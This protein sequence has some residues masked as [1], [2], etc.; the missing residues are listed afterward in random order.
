[1]RRFLLLAALLLVPA[2]ARAQQTTV[3]ATVTDP[4]GTAYNFSTGYAALVCPGNQQPTFNGFTVPR[5]FTITGFD[6]NGTFT[7]VVYDVNSILPAGCSYQWHITWQDGITSFITGTITSVTG[8][9]VNESTEISSYSVLLPGSHAGSVISCTTAGGVAYQNGT[10]NILTCDSNNVWSS[11]NSLLTL[12]NAAAGNVFNLVNPTAATNILNQHSPIAL[13][14]G[15]YWNGA[16]SAN[17][18][19][20]FQNLVQAGTNPA[21]T[22]T[23]TH[24]GSGAGSFTFAGM[25]NLGEVASASDIT[26]STDVLAMQTSAAT[27]IA[28]FNS[29]NFKLIGNYWN[30]AASAADTWLLQNVLGTGTNPTTT[31]TVTHTGSSGAV[32]VSIPTVGVTEYCGATSGATQ[33]CTKTVQTTPIVVFGD[34]TLNTATTQSITTLPF[35]DALYSCTGSDLTTAAGV[36]SFTSYLAASVTISETGGA[37]TDHL[38]YICVGR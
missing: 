17:D 27:N 32:A 8:A 37:N 35:T 19:Y 23:I 13:F 5:T 38:R 33:A 24:T 6:G 28:N 15:S 2:L 18:D 29:G 31:L 14:R 36:V 30:G 26:A 1:M 9:S 10:N 34:V 22:L 21:T 4:V 16:A 12:K 11:A 7:Q 3:T 25:A 20:T